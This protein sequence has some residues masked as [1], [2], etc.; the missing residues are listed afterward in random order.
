MPFL[1]GKH[2]GE[3][4][5]VGMGAGMGVYMGV[6][7]EDIELNEKSHPA[8]L[9]S[10]RISECRCSVNGCC[11]ILT[12]CCTFVSAMLCVSTMLCAIYVCTMREITVIV[13]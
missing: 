3:D 11:V 1:R 13:S 2:G 4:M 8:L 7:M 9:V 6:Y 5:A 10:L 12:A